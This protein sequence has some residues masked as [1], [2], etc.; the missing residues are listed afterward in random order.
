MTASPDEQLAYRPAQVCDMLGM[1]R[2]TLYELLRSGELKAIKVGRATYVRRADLEAYLASRP[3]WVP[4]EE[5][6]STEQARRER[7]AEAS[8]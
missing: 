6:E 2:A 8:G 1:P 4:A 5:R 7:A 3:A